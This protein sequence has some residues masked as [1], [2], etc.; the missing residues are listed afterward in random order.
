VNVPRKG[1]LASGDE[2]RRGR[3]VQAT[4]Q[5]VELQL[6]DSAARDQEDAPDEEE[7]ALGERV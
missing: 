3:D 6:V 4:S 2:P 1:G 7:G 5:P